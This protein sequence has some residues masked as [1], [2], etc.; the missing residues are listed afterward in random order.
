[1]LPSVFFSSLLLF[2]FFLIKQTYLLVAC[3]KI[4]VRDH[5][6]MILA[7]MHGRVKVRETDNTTHVIANTYNDKSIITP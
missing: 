1:M 3:K 4:T 6:S 5:I 2:L 7:I